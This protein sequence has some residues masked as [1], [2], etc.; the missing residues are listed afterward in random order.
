MSVCVLFA[1]WCLVCGAVLPYLIVKL[2]S[3][4]PFL[5]H[6]CNGDIFVLLFSSNSS[7]SDSLFVVSP[8][9]YITYFFLSLLSLSLSFN[10]G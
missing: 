9:S 10:A 1:V 4:V 5:A 2:Y 6:N 7:F 3:D 8:F